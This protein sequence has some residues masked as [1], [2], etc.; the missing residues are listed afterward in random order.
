MAIKR[1]EL[2]KNCEWQFTY[3]SILFPKSVWMSFGVHKALGMIFSVT[4]S[5]D[6]WKFLVNYLSK[7][8][9]MFRD[10]WG[11]WKHHCYVKNTVVIFGQL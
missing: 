6:F 11:I 1:D 4:R 3:K 7:V 10:L 2:T 9:Q 8:A 5:D